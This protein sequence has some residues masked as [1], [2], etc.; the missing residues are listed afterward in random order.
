MALSDPPRLRGTGSTAGGLLREYQRRTSPSE[1]AN[2]AAW[3]RLRGAIDA[4][5]ARL[6]APVT[7][8]SALAATCLG[9]WLLAPAG[10]ARPGVCLA[11]EGGHSG[12]AVATG[13]TEGT[14]GVR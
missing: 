7:L 3:R 1:A 6:R 4:P 11:A 13:G 2:T 10:D 5:P 9:I 12:S 8:W 14:S